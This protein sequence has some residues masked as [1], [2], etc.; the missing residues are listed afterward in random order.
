MHFYNKTL[1]INM[2]I[3]IFLDRWIV[4]KVGDDTI[5]VLFHCVPSVFQ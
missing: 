3:E 5:A 1:I 4:S 2:L